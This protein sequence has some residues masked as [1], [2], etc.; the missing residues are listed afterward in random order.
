MVQWKVSAF[1]LVTERVPLDAPGAMLPESHV[2]LSATRWCTVPSLFLKATV[3]PAA[4][5]AGLGENAVFPAE[6]VMAIVTLALVVDPVLGVVVGAGDGVVG[7]EYAPPPPPPQPTAHSA[8]AARMMA[9]I[10]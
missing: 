3:C 4:A 2:P 5:G 10:A 9:M 8:A 7:A 1:V 6:P